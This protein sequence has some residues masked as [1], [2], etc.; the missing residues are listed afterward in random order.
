M[1][2]YKE[3]GKYT[4]EVN[5]LGEAHGYGVFR[6]KGGD[7]YR[8]TFRNNKMDGYCEVTYRFGMVIAIG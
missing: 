7:I 1:T 2:V 5:K 4:G 6:S 3:N 8:G